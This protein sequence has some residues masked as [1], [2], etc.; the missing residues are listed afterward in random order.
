MMRTDRA[1]DLRDHRHR[2]R[3]RACAAG[4]TA[5]AT[6]AASCSSTCATPRASCRWS[7]TPTQS[8]GADVAPCAQRVRRAGRGARCATGPRARSTTRCPPARSRSRAT[9]LEVLNE[10]ETP[11]F[12][13]DDRIDADEM[14]RLRHRYL[15]LR[16][17]RLQ[18]NLRVRAQVNA[19][20]APLA[21]RAGLRRGR[22]ADAHR[23]DARGRA[24]LRRAVAAVAGRVLRAA[25]EPAAVQAAADGR[26]PRPLLPD[27]PLPPRRGPPR[28]PAVRVHAARRRDE[29]RRRRRRDGRDRRGGA[30]RGRG[31]H[32]RRARRPVGAHDLA[33]GAWSATAPTSPTSASASSSSTSARC[34]RPP[35]SA[36]SRPTR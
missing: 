30:R 4:S 8:A 5:A 25:A 28:R 23:V 6:T 35:S 1:G 21:R 7:S 9:A 16:R 13:V 33:P 19:R 17:P 34:S 20:A 15:D 24:R 22:D 3:R 27:R 14:L 10:A 2:P 11:P 32:R 12:P 36:R 29:L 26:R 18:R 31:G